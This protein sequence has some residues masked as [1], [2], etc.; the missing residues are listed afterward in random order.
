MRYQAEKNENKYCYPPLSKFFTHAY[1][2]RTLP[3]V[4]II[5]SSLKQRK[6]AHIPGSIFLKFYSGH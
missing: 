5:N 4:L 3:L 6:T 1:L 2:G